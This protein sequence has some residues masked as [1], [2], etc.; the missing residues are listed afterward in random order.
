MFQVTIGEYT[1]QDFNTK[2]GKLTIYH[3]SGEG[4]TFDREEFYKAVI[5]AV[6]NFYT[7]NF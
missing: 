4:G 1:I 5:A 6:H 7:E 2:S 3:K